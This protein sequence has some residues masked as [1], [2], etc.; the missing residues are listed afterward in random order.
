MMLLSQLVPTGINLAKAGVQGYKANQLSKTG[1]PQYNI[2]Q[3]VLDSVNQSR[4]LAS[5]K[6]LPGQNLMENK[7]GQNASKGINELKNV[8]A[9]GADLAS[10]VAR[11]YAGQNDAVNNLGIQAGQNWLNQ[12]GQLN[13]NLQNLGVYQEKAWD[14]NQ[15]Q[16]YQAAK[17][18]ESALREGAFRNLTSAGINIA[19]GLGGAAMMKY[20][21]GDTSMGGDG[22][23][24]MAPTNPTLPN[25]PTGGFDRKFEAPRTIGLTQA[26]NSPQQPAQTPA[27]D[28]NE[29]LKEL[30]NSLY[31]VNPLEQ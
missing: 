22:Q 15:N 13:N 4:Y 25:L 21:Q 3:G 24:T 7:L 16:P 10:N 17:A 12:Q 6:E 30:S 29:F 20:Q 31:G 19:S 26:I 2:P 1:R 18:A 28:A 9:N 11:I 14:Y 5:M 27:F 8:S 23:S